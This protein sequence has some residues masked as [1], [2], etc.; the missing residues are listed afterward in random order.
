MAQVSFNVQIVG[1]AVHVNVK[2]NVMERIYVFFYTKKTFCVITDLSQTV[3]Q[4]FA[5]QGTGNSGKSEVQ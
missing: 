4:H 2:N 3:T 5:K 1:L